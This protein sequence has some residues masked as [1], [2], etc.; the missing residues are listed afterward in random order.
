MKD[1]TIVVIG[2]GFVLTGIALH[3]INKKVNILSDNISKVLDGVDMMSN[4]IDIS[5]SDEVVKAAAQNAA[6]KAAESAV[7]AIKKTMANDIHAKVK[8]AVSE[9]SKGIEKD[10]KSKLEEQ[11]NLQTIDDIK[12]KVSGEIVKKIFTS[13]GFPLRF[14][15]SDSKESIIKTCAENGMS[16]WEIERILKEIK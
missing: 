5:V 6:N 12:N 1:T 13:N 9:A 2:A 14:T 8:E 16:A 3:L 10:V 4:N 11:I 15:S 7:T